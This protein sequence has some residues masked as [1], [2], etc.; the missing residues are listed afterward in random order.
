[1]DDLRRPR[2]GP[3]PAAEHRVAPWPA[4]RLREDRSSLARALPGAAEPKCVGCEREDGTLII[5]VESE[6]CEVCAAEPADDAPCLTCGRTAGEEL[7]LVRHAREADVRW[8]RCKSY[9]ACPCGGADDD[10]VD[11]GF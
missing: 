9:P 11:F 5:H 3:R 7:C 4:S 8:T 6:T 2:P 10:D 1:M